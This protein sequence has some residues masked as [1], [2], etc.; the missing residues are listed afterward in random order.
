MFTSKS[1]TTQDSY[2]FSDDRI[3]S[4]DKNDYWKNEAYWRLPPN[5]RSAID[6]AKY[7]EKHTD[8]W[9]R[10]ENLNDKIYVY[11]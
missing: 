9:Y 7:K 5:V 6:T 4:T 8:F 10:L 1:V 3:N 2:N 11:K